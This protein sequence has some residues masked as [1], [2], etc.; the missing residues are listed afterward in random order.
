MSPDQPSALTTAT[1]APAATDAP[2]PTDPA[3]AIAQLADAAGHASTD[4]FNFRRDNPA[5]PDIDR[6]LN[7]EMALDRHAIELRT[8]AIRMLGAQAADADAQLQ[9]AA[10]K[11]DLFIGTE[12]KIEARLAVANAVV[13]LAGAALVG[14]AGGVLSAAVNVHDALKSAKA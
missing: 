13:G 5:A 12:K 9:D 14:D 10:A 1:A 3:L 2:T 7:L 6:A 11:V 8:Q 4:L